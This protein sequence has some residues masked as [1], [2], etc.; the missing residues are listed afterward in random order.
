MDFCS[1]VKMCIEYKQQF[2]LTF[3]STIESLKN[4]S[5]NIFFEK[6]LMNHL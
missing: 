3:F 5:D 2:R 1:K 4:S 6:V